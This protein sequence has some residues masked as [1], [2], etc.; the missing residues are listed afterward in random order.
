[1]NEDG[2]MWL[3]L[4][5]EDGAKVYVN[6]DQVAAISAL[7]TGKGLTRLRTSGG[8]V[9]VQEDRKYIQSKVAI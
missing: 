9:D 1:M 5:T 7:A 3:E 2:L 6:F 8:N 4:T